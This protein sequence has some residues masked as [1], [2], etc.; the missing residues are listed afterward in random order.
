M[1]VFFRKI[2][3]TDPRNPAGEKKWY[4]I[5]KSLGTRRTK[6]IAQR[7]A[8][9]TTLNP[10]EAEIGL[11]EFVKALKETLKEGYTAQ[12]DDLGTFYLTANSSASETETDVNARNCTGIHIRFRPDEALQK[13]IDRI[14]L[15]PLDELSSK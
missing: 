15:K 1:A 14:R 9:E 4:I 7:M 10:K 3:R 5:L 11:Y 8:D 13:E 6:E 2:Q 12:I